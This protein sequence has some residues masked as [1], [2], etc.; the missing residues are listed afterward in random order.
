[1]SGPEGDKRGAENA[2]TE[3]SS[4]DVSDTEEEGSRASCESEEAMKT[5]FVRPLS[6]FFLL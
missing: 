1:M 2:A 4:G 5:L 6:A 3:G